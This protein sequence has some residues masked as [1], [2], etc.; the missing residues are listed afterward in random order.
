VIPIPFSAKPTY[1]QWKCLI[2]EAVAA[3]TQYGT[4]LVVFDTLSHLWCVQHENDNAEV[5]NA[6]MPLRQISNA[7]PGLLLTHHVGAGTSRSRGATEI[8]AF[9]DQL[10]DLHLKDPNDPTDRRRRL[11]IRG[12]LCSAPATLDIELNPE[13]TDYKVNDGDPPKTGKTIWDVMCE[14]VPGE[15]PGFTAKQFIENWPADRETPPE[16]GVTKNL[17]ERWEAAGWTREGTSHKGNPYRY[18]RVQEEESD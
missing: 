12:R 13:G 11:T 9:V 14:I 6:L 3:V 18:Y 4:D 2:D 17:G 5:A 15:A 10:I 7:G 1:S 16:K 8:G